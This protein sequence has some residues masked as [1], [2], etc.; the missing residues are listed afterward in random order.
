MN[1]AG[2]YHGSFFERNIVIQAG[3]LHEPPSTRKKNQRARD[4]YG[5][6]WSFR[7]IDF[8]RSR[9]M[10]DPQGTSSRTSRN[11]MLTERNEIKNW[12][13]SGTTYWG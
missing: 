5:I 11:A 6:N 10:D 12:W 9:H 1:A 3:P 4:G 13:R 7:V 8:G 2:W